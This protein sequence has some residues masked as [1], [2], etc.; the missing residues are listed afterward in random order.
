MKWNGWPEAQ[1]FRTLQR[2]AM[3]RRTGM[4][5]VAQEVIRGQNLNDRA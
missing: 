2:T 1:A 4:V 5:Q 3:D